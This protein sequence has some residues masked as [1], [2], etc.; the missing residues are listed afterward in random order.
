MNR[1]EGQITSVQVSGTLSL[2]EVT[3]NGCVLSAI[4]IDT[5][6]TASYLRTGHTVHVIF[7]ETE[8]IIGK[9]TEHLISLRNKLS[10]PIRSVEPGE[11]LSK[12]VVDTKAG[13]VTS[14]ITTRSVIQ[15]GLKEGTLVT[16]MIKT[17]EM[18]LSE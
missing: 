5:P 4:V 15:M 1:L 9:G 8:V 6:G 2:V 16:A 3:V 18:M 14:I 13:P 7:K 12:L 10:G 17:N 11:L